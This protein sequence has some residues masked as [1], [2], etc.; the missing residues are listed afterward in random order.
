MFAG[1]LVEAKF[2]TDTDTGSTDLKLS[3]NG[4]LGSSLLSAGAVNCSSDKTVYTFT[5]DQNNSFS[6]GDV[7]RV[8]ISPTNAGAYCTMSTKW[9]IS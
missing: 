5:C 1:T 8:H 4:T 9:K 7:V 3:V 6:A 2:Y